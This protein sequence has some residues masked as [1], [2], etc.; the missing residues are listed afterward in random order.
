MSSL[1]STTSTHT[2]LPSA[3]SAA[4]VKE[5]ISAL[6]AR[7]ETTQTH[8]GQTNALVPA[9]KLAKNKR[10]PA[11]MITPAGKIEQSKKAKTGRGD[12]SKK[13]KRSETGKEKA[14]ERME[15]LQAKVAR[16]ESKQVSGGDE[17]DVEERGEGGG[18]ARKEC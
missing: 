14:L 1:L 8:R 9:A 12:S 5:Q 13:K 18:C 7:K 11:T 2:D 17:G 16:S 3:A 10:L 6:A 4:A 15:Q